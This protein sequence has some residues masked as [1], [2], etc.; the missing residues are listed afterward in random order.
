MSK[1]SYFKRLVVLFWTFFKIGI[2]TFGGGY[3]ML[4]LI[5]REIVTRKKWITREE[6]L[7]IFAVAESTPGPVSVNTATYVGT[8]Q[9]GFLGALCCTLGMTLPSFLIIVGISFFIEEFLKF[10][11]VTYAFNGIRAGVCVIILNAA[12]RLLKKSERTLFALAII[13]FTLTITL[14]TGFS[15]IYTLLICA[16]AGIIFNFARRAVPYM[17]GD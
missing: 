12:L 15:I 10:T 13:I 11:I 2:I 17:R 3:S 9:A 5:E 14:L 8:R 16:A 6:M 1:E 7:N 4:G